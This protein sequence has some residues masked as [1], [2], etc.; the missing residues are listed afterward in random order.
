MTL[1]Q[2]RPPA[3]DE[4][5]YVRLPPELALQVERLRKQIESAFRGKSEV[6]ELVLV[7]LFARGH[8]LL[9]DVP[10]VGKTT[11]ARAVARSLDLEF[12]RIQFTSDLLPTDVLGVSIYNEAS[13]TFELQRGPLFA[14]L[15]LADEINRTT[16]RTQSALLEAMNERQV[17]ID[18]HTH[19]LEEPFVVIA[20]QN[21]LEFSG[22]YPLPESQ[23]D[24]FLVRT[25]IG[26]PAP[27]DELQI[28]RQ[29]GHVDPCAALAPVLDRGEVVKL[30]RAVADVRVSEDVLRYLMAIVQATRTSTQLSLGVSTRG[31]M[32]LFRAVQAR[33]VL[34]GRTYAVPD[35]VKRL[36]VPV[37]AHRV[38]L[39]SSPDASS[40]SRRQAETIIEELAVNMPIPA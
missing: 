38:T 28:I 34:Q 35:D 7:A 8:A 30:Q 31:A 10:G 39:R 9:E 16:P 21:P 26:Y 25:T 11:L 6:V 40:R 1:L 29:F 22:T 36:A 33:A 18:N 4:P 14:N 2:R 23:I 20:T 17:T 15:V 27:D 3:E 5:G 12:R 32:A 13:G 37:L 24:R 19:P